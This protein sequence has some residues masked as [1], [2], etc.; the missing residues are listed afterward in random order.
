MK[1]RIAAL[2]MGFIMI[3]PLI[4]CSGDLAKNNVAGEPGKLFDS[5]V[6]ISIMM[7]SSNNEPFND[8]WKALEYVREATGVELNI[9]AIPVDYQTKMALAFSA[10]DTLPD[11]MVIDQK[12]FADQYA[13]Q[14]ALIA[15]D[16]YIDIMPNW[17]KFWESVDSK[18]RD[19]LFIIRKSSDGKTYWPSR[20]GSQDYI[21]LKTWMYRK[22]IF[23]KHGL[24][25]PETYDE[26]YDLAVELKKLY[27]ESYPISIRNFFQN[28]AQ[29]IGP[30]WKPYFFWNVYYD[31]NAKKF[32]YGAVEDTMLDMIRFFKKLYDEGLIVKSYLTL[33][34][35]EFNE[36]ISNDRTFIFPQWQ[37]QIGLINNTNRQA[38]PEFTVAPMLPPVANSETGTHK[39]TKYSVD[40]NGYVICNTGDKGRIEN[41]I[42]FFDW[43][44]SDEACEL[45]SWGKAGETY[46]TTGG[47]KQFILSENEDIRN[48]YGLQT[49]GLGQ[50]LYPEVVRY[51]YM[52]VSDEEMDFMI[53]NTEDKYNPALWLDFNDE[54]RKVREDI[55]T[56]IDT[57]AQTMISKFL[58]GQ[59]PLSN[60]D[61]FVSTIKDMGVVELLDA[62]A[63]AYDR[64]K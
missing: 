60:W 47:E 5:P 45:L 25:P 39:M 32:S 58:L 13:Q 34:S 64:V 26:L 18:V 19:E 56:E 42:R 11:L 22:D 29:T 3:F 37:V 55:G 35:R 15:I 62:Y 8:N 28:G 14:G 59:E 20:Y 23:E 27:P 9:Q 43:F 49:Y 31:F 1:K 50:R 61:N 16:D 4:S 57:F 51:Y 10:P 2:V 53:E 21:G 12:M 7:P 63:S 44:Y 46:E 36:L 30:Q 40:T 38:N 6:K 33:Q 52:S 24:K 41:A 48:K 54:E 17:N